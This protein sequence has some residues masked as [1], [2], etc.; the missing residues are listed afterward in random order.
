MA[1]GQPGTGSR[2]KYPLRPSRYPTASRLLPSTG[3]LA[4][5]WL[6]ATKRAQSFIGGVPNQRLKAESNGVRVS[7]G[8]A[9]NLGMPKQFHVNVQSLLHTAYA[10]I[11]GWP[12]QP[13]RRDAAQQAVAAKPRA[14]TQNLGSSLCQMDEGLIAPVV[15]LGE[16]HEI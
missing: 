12:Y 10:T 9:R 16:E 7:G 3:H 14:S 11:P 5:A 1:P 8:M 15:F 4:S 2:P 6:R 13:Y